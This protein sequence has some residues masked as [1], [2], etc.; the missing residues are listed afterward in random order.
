MPLISRLYGLVSSR[1][2]GVATDVCSVGVRLWFLET[3]MDFRTVADLLR[4]C[5]GR[6]W[7]A[8]E[9]VATAEEFMGNAAGVALGVC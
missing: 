1:E 9:P 6:C 4:L 7:A 8:E 3:M 2:T 5:P